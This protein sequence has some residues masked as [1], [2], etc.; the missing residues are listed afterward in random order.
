[1]LIK[2]KREIYTG[3]TSQPYDF[4]SKVFLLDSVAANIVKQIAEEI[5]Y[6]VSQLDAVIVQ[7]MKDYYD[8]ADKLHVDLVVGFDLGGKYTEKDGEKSN[9]KLCDFFS[10][11]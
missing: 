1:M 3:Y 4:N 2:T 6:D 7:H 8:F 11:Y 5:N 10:C 9:K